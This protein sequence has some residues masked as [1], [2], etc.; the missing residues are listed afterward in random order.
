MEGFAGT[1]F[2]WNK[3]KCMWKVQLNTD[4]DEV[5]YMQYDSVVLYVGDNALNFNQYK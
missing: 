4:T 2:G 3:D 5:F 1:I